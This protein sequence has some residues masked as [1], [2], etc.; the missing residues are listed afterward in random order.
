MQ[1]AA[2]F[3]KIVIDKSPKSYKIRE[4]GAQRKSPVL[5]K[6]GYFAPLFEQKLLFLPLK[7]A[8]YGL[9][10]NSRIDQDHQQKQYW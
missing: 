6:K 5:S 7:L 4:I 2:D 1:T 8:I 3:S 9:K 10:A